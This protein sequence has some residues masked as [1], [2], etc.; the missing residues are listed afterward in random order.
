MGKDS[1]TGEKGDG[2]DSDSTGWGAAEELGEEK[3]AWKIPS[4]TSENNF[5]IKAL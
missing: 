2:D 3:T 4:V 5:G 1:E